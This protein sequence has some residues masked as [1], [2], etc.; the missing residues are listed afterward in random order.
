MAF[1]SLFRRKGAREGFLARGLVDDV[2]A[3]SAGALT[4]QYLDVLQ[5]AA[6]NSQCRADGGVAPHRLIRGHLMRRLRLGVLLGETLR[7]R[8]RCSVVEDDA[9]GLAEMLAQ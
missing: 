9:G 3:R 4:L 1:L 7:C 2:R 8:C 5:L 6:E